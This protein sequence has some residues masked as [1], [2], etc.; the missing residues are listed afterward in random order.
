[1]K[2][3]TSGFGINR[4]KAIEAALPPKTP[5][6]VSSNG[7]VEIEINRD[8]TAKEKSAVEAIMGKPISK[9]SG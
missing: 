9:E 5:F 1:M 3:K 4:V 6:K 7:E 8:L 2:Y